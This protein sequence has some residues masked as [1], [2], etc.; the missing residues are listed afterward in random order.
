ML[1]EP[2]LADTGVLIALFNSTDPSR[3]ACVSEVPSTTIYT[4]PIWRVSVR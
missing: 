1:N 3:E 2:V 4:E